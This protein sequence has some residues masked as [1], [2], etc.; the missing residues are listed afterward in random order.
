MT[1]EHHAKSQKEFAEQEG[2][3][4]ATRTLESMGYA[5]AGYVKQCEMMHDTF[6]YYGDLEPTQGA[7]SL[8]LSVGDC[9]K[10]CDD[11]PECFRW[12]YGLAGPLRNKCFLKTEHGAHMG[13]RAHFLS[14]RASVRKARPCPEE[15]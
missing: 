2:R 9:C 10:Q 14:G 7:D 15:L 6:W 3:K 1:K 11:H 4:L 13:H 12:S 5:N 8:A